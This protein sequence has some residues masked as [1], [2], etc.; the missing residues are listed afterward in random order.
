MNR[1]LVLALALA[2]ASGFGGAARAQ[3][4]APDDADDPVVGIVNGDEIHRSEVLLLYQGLPEE[5][6][7]LPMPVLYLQLLN[8]LVERK[9]TV[10]A[11][12]QAGLQD[13]TEVKRRMDFLGDAVLEDRYRRLQ[14]EQALTEERLRAAFER[15]VAEH[16]ASEEVRARHILVET[17][18]EAKAVIAELSAGADFIE[19]AKARSTGPSAAQGGDL[20]YFGRQDMVQ[21]FAEAAFALAAGEITQHPVKTQFGWH[22]IKIEARRSTGAPSFED[23]VEEL[24]RAE[25]QVVIEELTAALRENAE[26]E[27]FKPDGSQLS[28]PVEAEPKAQ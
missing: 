11:A 25:A 3:A 26:I 4:P 6:R 5:Y 2:L 15:M 24:R 20:G 23:S 22:V 17:E 18:A 8:R 7:R 28:L 21:E 9:L 27:L 13:D 10:R 12:R 14:V 1:A 16:Q 19:T